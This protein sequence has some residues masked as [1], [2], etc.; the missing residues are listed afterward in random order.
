M[1]RIYV[2][3]REAN[4]GIPEI[5][6]NMGVTV[7]MEQLDVADY[8]ITKDVA[9]ERKSVTD[10]ISSVFDKRL[11]DQIK[12]LSESY[13]NPI[14]LV[15]GDLYKI[16]KITER[17]K[18][19]NAALITLTLEYNVKVLYSNDRQESAEVIKRVAYIYQND[20][21]YERK[22]IYLHE[23]PKFDD[24]KDIQLYVIEAF[25]NIGPTLALKMLQRFDTIHNICNASVSDLEKVLG[26]RKRA[27]DLYRIIH[28]KFS[29]NNK[30]KGNEQQNSTLDKFI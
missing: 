9:I 6:K 23:K 20:N 17:W 12:R 29:E 30:D 21:R 14:L 19:I 4:S 15:E 27:E 3:N 18:A 24:L 11:F 16:R 10:L 13:S 22:A 7:I 26:S 28:A 1:L 8:V 25:P 5:L 2:D